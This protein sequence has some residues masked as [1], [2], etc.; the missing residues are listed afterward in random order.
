MPRWI[1]AR[2]ALRER[3]VWLV[4]GPTNTGAQPPPDW[5]R[6]IDG[7][8]PGWALIELDQ[9]LAIL[10]G[11]PSAAA[12][13]AIESLSEQYELL[14]P[15][16]YAHLWSPLLPRWQAEPARLHTLRPHAEQ[17]WPAPSGELRPLTASD[18][19][20][21]TG[22]SDDVAAELPEVLQR[23]LPNLARMEAGRLSCVAYCVACT[24]RW[25]DISVDTPERFRGQ[26]YAGETVSEL[27]RRQWATG[28]RP[29][30]GALVS[31][32]A[33]LRVAEKLGF[34]SVDE[35]VVFEAAE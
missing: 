12:V 11:R 8:D 18:L 32:R 31:N 5:R 26:G 30:W 7:S 34:T 21:A 24:E 14:A 35:L 28:R 10:L 20:Q 1:E 9:P 33:S 3:R 16:D 13:S 25:W 2:G 4:G 23:Q 22:L 29:V 6:V 15:P 27:I 17:L 19:K